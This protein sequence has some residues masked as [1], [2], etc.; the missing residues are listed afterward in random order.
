MT[1]PPGTQALKARLRAELGRA[2]DAIEV[3]ERARASARAARN[4]LTL[5][6]L[7]GAG[8]VLLYAAT[9][10]EIDPSPA[11]QSLVGRGARVLLPRGAG[12][13]LEVVPVAGAGELVPGPRGVLEPEGTAV[14][15]DLLDVAVVPGVGFDRA[16]GRLGRGGGHYDRLLGALPAATLRV[17]LCFALQVAE[18]VPRAG[19]DAPVDVV[20]TEEEVIRTGAR[21]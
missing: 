2:R 6:E 1:E 15:A 10:S 21:R 9:P 16:G 3:E 20:V 11:W 7:A 8:A 18:R 5:P 14:D 13:T 4:L 17:G 12:R 19:H